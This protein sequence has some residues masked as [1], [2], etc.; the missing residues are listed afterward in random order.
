MRLFV[1][2]GLAVTGVSA[3]QGIG[4]IQDVLEDDCQ[5]CAGTKCAEQSSECAA[6]PTCNALEECLY[7]CNGEPACRAECTMTKHVPPLS[8]DEMHAANL[9]ACIFTNCTSVCGLTPGDLSEIAPPDAAVA[10]RMSLETNYAGSAQTCAD[11]PECQR[12]L[13]CRENCVTGDC[14]GACA[15]SGTSFFSGFW[16]LPQE[17]NAAC[18]VGGNWACVGHVQWPEVSIQSQGLTVEL[19]DP[20]KNP[21]E[22]IT[23]SMCARPDPTCPQPLST[24]QTNSGGVV[25]LTAALFTNQSLG[26]DGFLDIQDTNLEPTLI[27]WGF[28]LSM[29]HGVIAFPIP[30]FS[31][32]DWSVISWP[33]DAGALTGG[34]IAAT[35]LDCFGEAAPGVT[36]S[37]DG[38]GAE[39]PAAVYVSAASLTLS[40][41]DTMTESNGIAFFIN[42]PTGPVD[43]IATPGVLGRPSGRVSVYAQAGTVTEA[44]ISPTPLPAD[45]GSA[46]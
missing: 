23:V 21:L 40:T 16:P 5:Y 42:V 44:A 39:E 10:C 46:P 22:G 13:L 45:A 30:V 38:G 34:V 18:D 20:F 28:P 11:D 29:L 41:T 9:D 2:A 27:Y 4:G 37:L 8:L 43:V 36:L 17:V 19:T 26:L 35:A 3:C 33:G 12:Y 14:V 32:L 15:G 6:S 7:G 24:A 25:S 1:A 31:T